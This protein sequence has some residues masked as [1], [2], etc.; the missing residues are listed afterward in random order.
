MRSLS[1]QELI[2]E[3]AA[4]RVT[5]EIIFPGR[6]R[7]G[8]GWDVRDR[9]VDSHIVYFVLQGSFEVRLKSASLNAGPGT[10]FWLSPGIPHSLTLS[11]A[12]KGLVTYHLRLNL[13]NKKMEAIRLEEDFLIHSDP[14]DLERWFEELFEDWAGKNTYKPHRLRA[15]LLLLLSSLFQSTEV[16][17]G[18]GS[19]QIN[20]IHSF[21]R[22]RISHNTRPSELAEL[23]GYTPVYFSRV[24]RNAFGM[25]PRS[26]ILREKIRQAAILL[27]ETKEP[28]VKIAQMLGYQNEFLLSRQFR[29][30]MGVS[31][32][33]FRKRGGGTRF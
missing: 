23:L 19:A 24:F 1:K 2:E 8:R 25:S 17:K 12:E 33:A 6:S 7:F 30:V 13:I 18:L 16:Y 9:K 22:K 14:Q 5:P 21:L 20:R 27:T 4:G 31:P 26:Y 32:M 10:F 11:S 28:V 15:R 3:L 29:E